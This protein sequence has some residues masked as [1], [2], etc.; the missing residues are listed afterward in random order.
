MSIAVGIKRA[1]K[2]RK[3]DEREESRNGCEVWAAQWRTGP[4]TGLPR[5]LE[6]PASR[7]KF[8]RGRAHRRHA[9]SPLF[10]VSTWRPHSDDRPASEIICQANRESSRWADA[11]RFGYQVIIDRPR[12]SAAGAGIGVRGFILR[13]CVAKRRQSDVDEGPNL[14]WSRRR[15][16]SRGPL[17]CLMRA[18]LRAP[19]HDARDEARPRG[20]GRVPAASRSI[21]WAARQGAAVRE[22]HV[23]AAGRRRGQLHAPQGRQLHQAAG[24]LDH[25]DQPDPARCCHHVDRVVARWR[26]GVLHLVQFDQAGR[27]VYG[28][29][30]GGPTAGAHPVARPGHGLRPREPSCEYLRQTRVLS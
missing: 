12:G 20:D 18:G 13:E 30:A 3:H 5:C 17:R 21:A 7:T 9:R 23:P 15:R 8:T 25:P 19:V 4:E 27:Q 10:F 28:R 2:S 14:R 26:T 24:H 29:A 16:R 22:R 11:R 1:S 6:R